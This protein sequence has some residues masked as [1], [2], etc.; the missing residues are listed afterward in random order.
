MDNNK[1]INF[2]N[3]NKKYTK[4]TISNLGISLLILFVLIDFFN[5]ITN[6]FITIFNNYAK[7]R[8][9]IYGSQELKEK[10]NYNYSQDDD[11][12]HKKLKILNSIRHIKINNEKNFEDIVNYK[13]KY[14]LD[15]EIKAGVDR[16]VLNNDNDN[17]KYS[18][19]PNIFDFILDIFK[20]TEA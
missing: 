4:S 17:Y 13:K 6:N 20:P 7:D 12:E 11:F 1:L 10:D 9:L 2:I 18:S 19:S 5:K 14:Q 16:K 3:N 8:R 15:S